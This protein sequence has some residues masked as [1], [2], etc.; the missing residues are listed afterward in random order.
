MHLV[1]AYHKGDAPL[2]LESAKAIA[3]QGINPGHGASICCIE[4]TPLIEEIRSELLKAFGV[5]QRIV[6]TDGF[7]G[8][9]LGPN[10]MF[11]D[12]AVQ[13]YSGGIP[14]MFWEP[15]CVPMKPRWMDSLYE[16][17]KRK[18]SI[19]GHIY[20]ASI[21]TN[22]KGVNNMVVGA[23]IYP[24]N[25]LDYCPLARNLSQYNLNYKN[26][27]VLPQPWDVYCRYEFLKIARDTPLIRTYWKSV[28]YQ[29]KDGRVV[30]FAEDPEAQAI[31]NVTC[32]DRTLS[33]EA[34]VVHGCKDGSLHRAIVAQAG[35]IGAVVIERREE[36]V[37]E[38]PKKKKKRRKKMKISE[39]DRLRRS[40]QMLMLNASKSNLKNTQCLT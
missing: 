36:T 18:P 35:G 38:P 2:A 3:A 6:A 22:G 26:S 11:S 10:Q 7:D 13:R 40:N 24:H 25:F 39:A 32:P 29:E 34:L 4:G 31:Q 16:Q 15:D 20:E 33:P 17:Y 21:G 37:V 23:A 12:A 28:N 8:W 30:F 1:F 19:L 9:P 27:G 14:W 5:V